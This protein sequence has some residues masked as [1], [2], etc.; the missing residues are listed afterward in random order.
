M[1]YVKCENRIKMGDGL[2][3]I[4]FFGNFAFQFLKKSI[5]LHT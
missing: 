3:I 4:P 1:G 5:Y 2:R